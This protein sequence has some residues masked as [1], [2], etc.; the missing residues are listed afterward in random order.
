MQVRNLDNVVAFA[1]GWNQSLALRSDGAVWTWGSNEYGQ[2]GTGTNAVRSNA[3]VK[4]GTLTNVVA[5]AGG[6]YHNLALKKDGT[7]WAW[8]NNQY[9]Q[10]GDGSNN[11]SNVPLRVPNLTGIVALGATTGRSCAVKKDGTVWWWGDGQFIPGPEQVTNLTGVAKVVDGVALKTNGTV[12]TW[13]RDSTPTQVSGLTNVAAIG[14]SDYHGVAL[15]KDGTVWAW[16]R[17]QEGQLG[18]G[19]YTDSEVP[20]RVSNVT[21][22]MAVE[23]GGSHSVAL[24]SDGKIWVWGSNRDRAIRQLGCSKPLEHSGGCR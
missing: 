17:N 2:L 15:K 12:W 19:T 18:N 3:P 7:V 14:A 10:L 16:G 11:H 13:D 4:V 22:V 24:K 1:G 5:I 8:G 23:A 21:G 9:G 20:V 6:G